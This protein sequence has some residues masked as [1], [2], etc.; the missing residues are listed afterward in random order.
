MS[1]AR[2]ALFAHTSTLYGSNPDHPMVPC[3]FDM[4]NICHPLSSKSYLQ[5]KGS[6]SPSPISSPS[7]SS[8]GPS[9]PFSN[10][11]TSS[12][13]SGHSSRTGSGSS[14]A[15]CACKA[16][17]CFLAAA[18]LAFAEAFSNLRF[19]AALPGSH[20]RLSPIIT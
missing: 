17:F 7:K 6:A 4:S 12:S 10:P 2:V 5:K 1:P 8:S 11:S 13:S 9:E 18:G 15:G 16:C 20:G 3:A 14:L 19:S